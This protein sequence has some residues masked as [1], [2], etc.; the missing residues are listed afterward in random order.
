M[1]KSDFQ[2]TLR[3]QSLF[4]AR[5]GTEEE[6]LCALKKHFTPPFALVKF[7]LPHQRKTVK[8][9]CIYT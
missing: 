2:S 1:V 6:M 8:Q 3:E 4:M 7:S 5:V 9:G